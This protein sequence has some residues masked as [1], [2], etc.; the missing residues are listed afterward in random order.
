MLFVLRISD[1]TQKFFVPRRS[2]HVIGRSSAQRVKDPD[3]GRRIRR[4]RPKSEWTVTECPTLI[5]EP[6]WSKVQVRM[7]ERATGRKEGRGVRRYLLSGLLICERCGCP[8]VIRGTNGSHYGCSTY[9]HGGEAACSMGLHL[10]RRVAEE[11]VLGPVRSELLAPEA[12]DRFCEQIRA[13]ARNDSWRVEQGMDPAVAAIDAEIADVEALIEARP[14]RA[15]TMRP[16]IE[17]LRTK[18]ANLRRV[19][20]RKAQSA[21]AADLPAVESYR[22]AVAGLAETLAGSNVEAART[23]LR[24]L[25]GTVPVFAEGRK[26]Y[27]RLGLDHAQLMRSSNPH[28][29]ESCG[30]GGRI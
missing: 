23:A 10:P 28:L 12:V 21:K 16:L 29:I 20:A 9:M 18:Q 27:G 2:A 24:G 3:S 5:D 11:V 1:G 15:A 7:K 6:T 30:S 26:L 8:M 13:W 14:A 17:E 22:A 25:V 19:A 4:E